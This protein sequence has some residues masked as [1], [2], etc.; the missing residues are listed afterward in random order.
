MADFLTRLAGR[1]LGVVPTVQPM[2]APMYAPD[3]ALPGVQAGLPL[4]EEDVSTSVPGQPWPAGRER[5]NLP[6]HKPLPAPTEGQESEASIFTSPISFSSPQETLLPQSDTQ[7]RAAQPVLP[8]ISG[9]SQSTLSSIFA[10]SEEGQQSVAHDMPL[11][12]STAPLP[13][14]ERAKPL[15]MREGQAL[16][17]EPAQRPSGSASFMAQEQQEDSAPHTV[18]HMNSAE[19]QRVV[20]NL[21]Q[22]ALSASADTHSRASMRRVATDAGTNRYELSSQEAAASALATPTIQVTIGR[23]EVRATQPPPAQQQ[24]SR[25]GPRVM[26]LEEYLNQQ[27]KGGQ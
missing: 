7:A 16:P 20:G 6:M 11:S 1:T 24:S 4:F 8:A 9:D 22:S 13:V 27:A 3:T 15:H 17:L 26:S 2:I 14:P 19:R 21:H 12:P 10:S 18:I 25:P 23:I 5:M